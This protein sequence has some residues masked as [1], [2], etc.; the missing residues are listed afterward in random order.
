[1]LADADGVAGT[2]GWKQP[3]HLQVTWKH[4]TWVGTLGAPSE[5]FSEI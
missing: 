3:L 1:M 5:S 4:L 2:K